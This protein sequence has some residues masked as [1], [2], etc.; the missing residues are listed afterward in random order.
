[1][2]FDGNGDA[3]IFGVFERD[4]AELLLATL[5]PRLLAIPLEGR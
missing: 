4:I 5:L 3:R 2:E 1:V